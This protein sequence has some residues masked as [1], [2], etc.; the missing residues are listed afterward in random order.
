LVAR[1]DGEMGR[2]EDGE[3]K[4]RGGALCPPRGGS[5][6]AKMSLRFKIK[7]KIHTL[8]ILTSSLVYKIRNLVEIIVE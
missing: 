5:D 8:L 4:R 6:G 7:V 1:G 2:G 3:Q